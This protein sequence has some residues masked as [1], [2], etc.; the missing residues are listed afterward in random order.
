MIQSHCHQHLRLP[1]CWLA[2]L[3]LV[4]R[5]PPVAELELQQPQVL[6]LDL[7][8]HVYAH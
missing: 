6:T 8:D 7:E 5:H 4:L 1:E 3:V 2:C